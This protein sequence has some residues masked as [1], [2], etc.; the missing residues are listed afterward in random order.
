MKNGPFFRGVEPHYQG[1][2][3][4]GGGGRRKSRFI[5]SLIIVQAGG[6]PLANAILNILGVV[7]NAKR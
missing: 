1:G 4:G 6:W 5:I 2:G 7:Y 3:G